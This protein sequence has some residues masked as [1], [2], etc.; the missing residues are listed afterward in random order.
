MYIMGLEILEETKEY[1]SQVDV[2]TSKYSTYM[3]RLFSMR[4][5]VTKQYC[6]RI[7]INLIASCIWRDYGI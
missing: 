7:C 5:W 4:K 3:L 2:D 6:H 1:S